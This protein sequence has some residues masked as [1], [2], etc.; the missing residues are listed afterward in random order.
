MA[1]ARKTFM[2]PVLALCLAVPAMLSATTPPEQWGD[3]H[4]DPR[5]A[6]APVPRPPTPACTIGIIDHGFADFEPVH[7]R[8]DAAKTCPGPWHKIVLEMDGAVKGRQYDRIGHLAIGGVTVFRTSSPEPSREG[9]AWHVEKD[10]TAYAPL[11]D[12]PQPVEMFL[13]NLVNETYTGVFRIKARLVF[14]AADATHAAADTADIVAPL[15]GLRHDGPDTLGTVVL[16]ANAERL[17]AEV[18]ATGSGGGC[19]EF[20]YLSAPA[21]TDAE[22]SCKDPQGPYREVQVLVDG[23]VAGIAAPYPHI[24]TGGWSNPILW[25]PIPAPRA[26]DIKPVQ[27]DLTPFI[28]ALNDGKPHELRMRVVGLG[29]AASGGVGWSLQPNVQIWRDAAVEATRGAL[30]EVDAGPLDLHNDVSAGKPQEHVLVSRSRHAFKARGYLITSRG[31]VETTVQR[32]LSSRIR[33]R[34]DERDEYD[35]MHGEWTDLQSVSRQVGK[36]APVVDTQEFR[37]GLDGAILTRA[38]EGKARRLTTTLAI[39]DD[40]DHRVMQGQRSAGSSRT[41]DRFNGTASYNAGVPREQRMA[42]GESTQAYSRRDGDGT[43]FARVI[44]TRNGV[45]VRDDTGCGID[46]GDDGE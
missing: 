18:Y 39:H 30:L 34:W 22:Y 46:P 35:G 19:E 29:T 6:H 17:V 3:D 5:T 2:A 28:G 27:F 42:T 24:Y 26:F 16:P 31:R 25:Y 38:L 9:I 7:A 23:R 8:L 43:C 10:L 33:H 14:H 41:R 15:Q 37:F 11:F 32:D 12:R 44:S 4:D 21:A 1:R 40:A 13:G 20:W 45:F 36:D